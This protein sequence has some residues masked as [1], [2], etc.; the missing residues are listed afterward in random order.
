VLPVYGDFAN[1]S[2]AQR[3]ALQHPMGLSA[4]VGVMSNV[5]GEVGDQL[6]PP[7]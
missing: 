4:V 5:V 2:D 6:G 7:G 1:E 3:T